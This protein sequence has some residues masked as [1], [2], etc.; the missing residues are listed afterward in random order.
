M[1]QEPSRGI[2]DPLLARLERLAQRRAE[3]Q[4]FPPPPGARADAPADR[5]TPAPRTRRRHPARSARIGALVVSCASTGALSYLF[6]S[7][8]GSDSQSTALAGLPAPI[9]TSP[10][11]TTVPVASTVET[12]PATTAASPG[13]APATTV[14]ATTVTVTTI[15]ATTAQTG[16]FDGA[17]V[18]TRYGPVQ[19]Q[20]QITNGSL[21]E[22][23]IVQ[24][25]D[26]DRKSLR[27]NQ[28]ALPTLREEALTAQ[29]ANVDSVSGAT[30][31][32]DGYA[33]SLQSALDAARAA[34]VVVA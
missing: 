24:Y 20:V 6:A 5:L 3:S 12:V 25:P 11:A 7:S 14:P 23:A 18:D 17:V 33:Q 16:A 27:I 32:S 30:Y 15:P 19:V 22:V 1:S 4:P 34:G 9:A 26:G 8:N 13:I 29:S 10:A 31:T 21:S 2:D 28:R